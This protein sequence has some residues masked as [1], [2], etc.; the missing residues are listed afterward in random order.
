MQRYEVV[1]HNTAVASDNKIHDDDVARRFGFRGGLVPGVDV[2][3]YLTHPLVATW[4]NDWLTGGSMEVRF[5]VP[6]YD[7]DLTV[8]EAEPVDD[9]SV[10]VRAVDPAGT[11]C[12]VG[13]ATRRHAE[14]APR[15]ADW[16]VLPRPA[17]R[18]DAS[19]EAF[20]A[21][22]ES[23]PLPTLYLTLT[24]DD[25]ATYLDDVREDLPI[26]AE[27]AAAHP[28][29]LL[30]RANDAITA[31][32]RLG[33]WI[34][35][36]STVRHHGRVTVGDTVEVRTRLVRWWEAKG[37]RFANLDVALVVD[38]EVRTTIDHTAIYEPRP[39]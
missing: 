12:A 14:P 25:A 26:Y 18:P 37:H 21:Y 36:G 22:G 7:G 3:A 15:A 24:A 10:Q 30:R 32:V 31:A 8:V 38:D 6:V 16:D 28:G 11:V 2:Y 27:A 33:P 39:S 1:A 5:H 23:G 35:V 9:H 13:A 19:P 29:W 17:H 4:G 34:H 20:A